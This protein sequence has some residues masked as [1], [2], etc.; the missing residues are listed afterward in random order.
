MLQAVAILKRTKGKVSLVVARKQTPPGG[1][2]GAEKS[3]S[4][5][6]SP[7]RETGSPRTPRRGPPVATKPARDSMSDSSNPGSP[8]KQWSLERVPAEIVQ[9]GNGHSGSPAASRRE[10]EQSQAFEPE[11]QVVQ[12]SPRQAAGRFFYIREQQT[13]CEETVR[14]QF[15]PNLQLENRVCGL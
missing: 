12:Q 9:T 7:R 8:R 11:V 6:S 14:K 15:L 2:P 13:S 5:N 3:T 10:P 4:A 1:S